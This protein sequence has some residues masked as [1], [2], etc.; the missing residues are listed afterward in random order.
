MVKQFAS[1]KMI[2]AIFR[3]IPLRVR[4]A[5][6]VSL[7]LLA[8][9]LLPRRRLITIHNLQRAFPEKGLSE[10]RDIA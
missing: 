6:F 9:H 7:S 5:C 8:Y 10:I 2:L 1:T 4:K 3:A